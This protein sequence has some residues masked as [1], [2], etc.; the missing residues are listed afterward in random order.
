MSHWMITATGREHHLSGV[1]VLM[2]EP[3]RWDIAWSLAQINRY[4][5]HA[6]RPYSVAEHA[7]LTQELA[8][9]DGRSA[10]V[11]LLCLTHDDHESATGDVSSPAKMAVGLTWTAFEAR[12]ADIFRRRAGLHT[13]FL[14][15]R[16]TVSHYDL[17]ALATER[18][19]LTAYDPT[20]NRPWPILD[21]PGAEVHPAEDV[22]L[23]SIE[24][25]NR[26]WT[27][28]REQYLLRFNALR[29]AI[30]EQ[31]AALLQS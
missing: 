17:L 19:Q 23:N 2:S 1:E 16:K 18:K 12:Q 21:T 28:W 30:D 7:I 27:E 5:G 15:H 13:A 25:L 20:R 14:V 10:L 11:Q 31:A 9:R 4:T 26:H 8:A 24:R 29:A 22:D 3:T 6:R